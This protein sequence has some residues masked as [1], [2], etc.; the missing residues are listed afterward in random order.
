MRRILV[1]SI[2]LVLLNL[3]HAIGAKADATI[4][5]GLMQMNARLYD[6]EFN[7]ERAEK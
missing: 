1:S 4:R 2:L 6:G 3:A 5:V 7:L